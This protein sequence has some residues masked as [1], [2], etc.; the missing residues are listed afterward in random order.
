MNLFEACRKE[1]IQRVKFFIEKG[2]DIEA[3]DKMDGLL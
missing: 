2:A 3:R 1:D